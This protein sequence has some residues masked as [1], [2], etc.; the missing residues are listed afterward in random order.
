MLPNSTPHP[1]ARECRAVHRVMGARLWAWTLADRITSRKGGNVYI[2]DDHQYHGAALI[3]IAEH[4]EF[5]AINSLKLKGK[6]VR[7]AYKINKNIAVYVKYAAKPHGRFK[8]YMFT[9]RNEHLDTI[10]SLS[11]ANP[12]SFVA[13][14]CVKGRHICCLTVAE[15]NKLVETRKDEAGKTEDQYLILVTMPKGKSMRVYVNQP[16]RKK[17]MLGKPLIVSRN[18]FPAVLF[19]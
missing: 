6:I 12:K 3:Q 14:V 17:T 7:A 5:T 18:A 8:E 2:D 13:L 4:P 9:F 16:G 10:S 15:L 1:D 19:G 11:K